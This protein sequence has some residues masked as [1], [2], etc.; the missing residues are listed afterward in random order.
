MQGTA[1]TAEFRAFLEKHKPDIVFLQEVRL[2]AHCA[3]GCAVGD[4]KPRSRGVIR[5]HSK[6]DKT[7]FNLVSKS[8]TTWGYEILWSLAD[9]KYAGTGRNTLTCATAHNF[10]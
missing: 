10:A 7:D 4:G 9:K 3:Q 8:I 6:A 2:P 1:T 5:Q